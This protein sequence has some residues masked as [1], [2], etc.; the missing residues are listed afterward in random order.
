[1]KLSLFGHFMRKDTL[2]AKKNSGILYPKYQ[3]K[4][5]T[6]LLLAASGWSEEK[7]DI[8]PSIKNSM[9]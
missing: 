4:F 5:S 7:E 8:S 3:M 9:H 1:M 2:E 6:S